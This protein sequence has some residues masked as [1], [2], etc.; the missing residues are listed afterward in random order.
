MAWQQ[1]GWAY[2]T[3]HNPLLNMYASLHTTGTS[4]AQPTVP[5]EQLHAVDG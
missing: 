4:D 3:E 5:T 2:D 1:T